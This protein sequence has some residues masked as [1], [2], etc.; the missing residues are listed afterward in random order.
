ML[1]EKLRDLRVL[2][3]LVLH[4]VAPVTGAVA[5]GDQQRA[6]LAVRDFERFGTPGPPVHGVVHV[7]PEIAAGFRGQAVGGE[8]GLRVGHDLPALRIGPLD[9]QKREVHRV[10][11]GWQRSPRITFRTPRRGLGTT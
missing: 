6:I 9:Y 8:R 10:A 1:V 5:D 2:E 4:D 3:G 7:L 11:V